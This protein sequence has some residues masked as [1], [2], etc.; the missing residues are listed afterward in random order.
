MRAVKATYSEFAYRASTGLPLAANQATDDSG[1][2][3]AF[4][5][6]QKGSSNALVNALV[7]FTGTPKQIWGLL[8]QFQVVQGKSQNKQALYPSQQA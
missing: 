1:M 5:D 8:P 7:N 4:R 6:A 2:R 3:N